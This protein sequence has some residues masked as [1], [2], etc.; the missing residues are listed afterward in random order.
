MLTF[1]RREKGD[2]NKG[3]IEKNGL[4]KVLVKALQIECGDYHTAIL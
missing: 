4:R 3:Y 1:G 2:G